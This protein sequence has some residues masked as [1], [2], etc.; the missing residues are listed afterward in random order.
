MGRYG[1][2]KAKDCWG[3]WHPRGLGFS[4]GLLYSTQLCVGIHTALLF[5]RVAVQHRSV[6]I[7]EVCVFGGMNRVRV[8]LQDDSVEKRANRCA[9]KIFVGRRPS[10]K[11]YVCCTINVRGHSIPAHVLFQDTLAHGDDTFRVLVSAKICVVL[12][13]ISVFVDKQGLLSSMV[14]LP[15]I[16]IVK[17]TD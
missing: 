13:L 9:Y 11:M 3:C 15:S 6:C 1:R 8:T 14:A 12:V 4:A 10:N 2:W 17:Q 5:G 7:L 16:S